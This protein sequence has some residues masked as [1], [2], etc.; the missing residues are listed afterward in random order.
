MMEFLPHITNK[1][2]ETNVKST[3][4]LKALTDFKLK[5]Q[6]SFEQNQTMGTNILGYG[7]IIGEEDLMRENTKSGGPIYTNTLTCISQHGE[8]YSVKSEDF[9]RFVT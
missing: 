1:A 6:N 9:K 8:L 2:Y 7:K 3:R 4:F 5:K